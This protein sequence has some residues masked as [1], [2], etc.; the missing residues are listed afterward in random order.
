MNMKAFFSLLLFLLFSSYAEATIPSAA[1][2]DFRFSLGYLVCDFY[3]GVVDDDVTNS[4]VKLQ[5]CIDDA[6]DNQLV[7]FLTGCGTYRI[8]DTLTL[9]EWQLWNPSSSPPG[10]RTPP[11]ENHVLRGT[12]TCSGSIRPTLKLVNG[13]LPTFDTTSLP[14]PMLAV[15]QFKA[16][17][18]AA[19]S[20][21]KPTNPL[22]DPANFSDF[23]PNIFVILIE[24]INFDTNS[25]AGAIGVVSPG[26]QGCGFFNSKITATNSFAGIYGVPEANG[27][28]ANIEIIGGQSGI[29]ITD[30]IA[31][32][33]FSTGSGANLVGITLTNQ[34]VTSIIIDRRHAPPVLVGIT[35]TKNSDGSAILVSNGAAIVDAQITMS[36]AAAN[37]IA[38]D[39]VDG[40][41]MYVRET[42]ISGS[43]NLIRS[44]GTTTTGSGTWAKLLEYAF[45]DQFSLDVSNDPTVFPTYD[46][47]AARVEARSV[48]EGVL[49]APAFP[50]LSKANNVAAPPSDLI[51]RHL[52]TVL[53]SFEDGAFEDP[54]TYGAVAAIVANPL[55]GNTGTISTTAIQ[56]AIDN[57]ALAGHNRVV[58]PRGWLYINGGLTL[59]ANTKL[60]GAGPKKSGIAFH[61]NWLPIAVVPFLTTTDSSTSAVYV[62]FLSLLI[63]NVPFANDFMTFLKWRAG[64]DSMTVS[65]DLAAPS[66]V[67]DTAVNQ[68]RNLIEFS[69]NG[70]GRHYLVT[71]VSAATKSMDRARGMRLVRIISATQPLTLY[72]CNLE[73]GKS[74]RNT[75]PLAN[76]EMTGSTAGFR[77]Y[78]HKREGLSP[79]TIITDSSNVGFFG[80]GGMKP[81]SVLAG[82]GYYHVSGTSSKIVIAVSV[83][84]PNNLANTE[85]MLRETITSQPVLN[86]IPWP[87]AISLYK[88]GN[89]DDTPFSSSPSVNAPRFQSATANVVDTTDVC[90]EVFDGVAILPSSGATGMTFTV[91]AVGKT[92]TS[93]VRTGLNCYRATFAASTIT[94][95]TNVVVVSY[96]PGNITSGGGVAAEAFSNQ[97][98]TNLLPPAIVPV[99]TMTRYLFTNIYDSILD[100]SN[101]YLNGVENAPLAGPKGSLFLVWMKVTNTVAQAAAE[102]LFAHVKIDGA[103][104]IPLADTCT[105]SPIAFANAPAFSSGI[106][107][108]IRQLTQDQATFIPGALWESFSVPTPIAWPLPPSE[109][110]YVIPIQICSTATLSQNFRIHLFRAGGIPFASYNDATTPFFNT[111]KTQSRV[112]GGRSS[113]G[114]R[115]Q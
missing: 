86:V 67:S 32:A 20:K 24:G 18:S 15:R 62:G 69:G 89:L 4:T 42:W 99:L 11:R 98:A 91:D 26:A 59:A 53:P 106:P 75:E 22:A 37:D 96:S 110:E 61:N 46:V 36:G 1:S 90:F 2:S 109:T 44:G 103:A 6:Y 55:D 108:P 84:N 111:V 25:H 80:G 77:C 7:A 52:W 105:S 27:V 104:A 107:V 114:G 13:S 33:T 78:G 50:V 9:Y 38:I 65:L 72:G 29:V 3:S 21:V 95:D 16:L 48:V 8:S 97:T 113:G 92:P 82:D 41:S 60:I 73:M 43:T 47:N 5:E 74:G 85:V 63:R 58:I 23:T 68:P 112:T 70:G 94:V 35:I 49:G 79:T 12:H 81:P 19:T 10:P 57:A 17:N 51:S 102:P 34:T 31:S 40:R 64:K 100:V 14:R 88:R 87:T 56:T 93:V 101:P 30:N 39:N 28:T 71:H 83:P 66:F 54:R 115:R 76:I 45:N